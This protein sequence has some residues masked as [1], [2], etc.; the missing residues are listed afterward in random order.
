MKQKLYGIIGMVG[1]LM[2]MIGLVSAYAYRTDGF[3][4]GMMGNQGRYGMM[5]SQV[6]DRD[7]VSVQQMDQMHERMMEG[8]DPETAKSMDAMHDACTGNREQD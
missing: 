7:V 2:L 6:P 5:N 4:V 1:V 8:L 3:G